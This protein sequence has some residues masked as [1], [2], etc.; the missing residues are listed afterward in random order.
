MVI[1]A[2]ISALCND[3]QLNANA[4]LNLPTATSTLRIGGLNGGNKVLNVGGTLTIGGGSVQI[5]GNAVFS[6]T[7]TLNM[8]SGTFIVDGNAAVAANSVLSGTDLLSF[9]SGASGVS[10]NVTGGTNRVGGVS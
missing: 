2:G 1:P 7:S 5:S 10:I 8:S 4:A 9:T 3:V 6:A